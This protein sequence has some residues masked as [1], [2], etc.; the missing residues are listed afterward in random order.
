[1]VLVLIA[2]V[3]VGAVRPNLPVSL[4]GCLVALAAILGLWGGLLQ[5]YPPAQ[6]NKGACLHEEVYALLIK[7]L[8][9]LAAAIGLFA[10]LM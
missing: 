2:C 10:S 3:V 1:M 8:I 5:T 9:V 4:Q 7:A 6:S